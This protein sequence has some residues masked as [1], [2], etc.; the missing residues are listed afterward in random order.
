[1]SKTFCSSFALR[2][3]I[4]YTSRFSFLCEPSA[5]S[6]SLPSL[7]ISVLLYRFSP[8]RFRQVTTHSFRIL[9]AT[10][11]VPPS[12]Q[13]F[14]FL[15]VFILHPS[16]FFFVSVRR[17]QG[18]SGGG[19]RAPSTQS[20]E[21]RTR[22]TVLILTYVCPLGCIGVETC[23]PSMPHSRMLLARLYRILRGN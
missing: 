9:L 11:N 12:P 8:S 6:A 19:P 2:N 10:R 5:S 17:I 1:M 7:S 3:S 15:P 21:D 4:F 22:G 14:S 18:E 13:S 23:F 20:R 16:S